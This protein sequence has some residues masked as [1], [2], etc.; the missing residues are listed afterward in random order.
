[1]A[2]NAQREDV[3]VESSGM[4]G[5]IRTNPWIASTF[6]LSAVLL[7]ALIYRGP[8]MTGN[9][10]STDEAG[11]NLIAFAQAQGDPNAELVSIEQEG[12]LY[13]AVLKFKDQ[14]VPVMVT[15]DG[16]YLVSGAIPLNITAEDTAAAADTSAD[17]QTQQAASVPKSTKP[18][19]ELFVMS[20]CPYGT[21]AEKGIIPVAEL[22]GSKIDFK[23]RFVS[24]IMHGKPEIDENTRQYCIQKEQPSKLFSYMNCYLQS[25]KS[26]GCL[27]G[28]DTTKVNSC[29]SSADKTFNITANYD[30]K[31]SWLS[32]RFPVYAVDAAKNK[33][34]DVQGS[35]TLV[36]NGVQA[37]SARDSASLLKAVC[38]AFT[39]APSECSKT[40]SSAAPSPGFGS[41]TAS[42]GSADAAQCG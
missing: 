25:G 41:G 19:V 42:S 33:E 2:N 4:L 30:D 3:E 26:E 40:L 6:F 1:M 29:I 5:K 36:I 17:T 18:V 16:N 24:Y 37:S 23:I 31:S 12:A 32:G 38:A 28:I 39:T 15:L 7:V 35:P 27:S 9:V 8:G 14:S 22:L 10:V 34:Y 20:L 13:N 11:K 21:Q